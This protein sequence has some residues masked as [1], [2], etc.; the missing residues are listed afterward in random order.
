MK[1]TNRYFSTSIARPA[2]M[3]KRKKQKI[4]AMSAWAS[5]INYILTS[6]LSGRKKNEILSLDTYGKDRN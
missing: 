4:L 6:L 5:I 1:S 2:S 3:R